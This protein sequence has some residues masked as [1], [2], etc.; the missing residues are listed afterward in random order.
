MRPLL[1]WTGPLGPAWMPYNGALHGFALDHLM[2]INLLLVCG[3]LLVSHLVLIVAIFRKGSGETRRGILVV[4]SVALVVIVFVFVWMAAT[5][6]ALWARSGFVGASPQAMQVEAVGAQFQWYFRYPGKDAT[7]GKTRP[8]L[9]DAAGGNPLGIDPQDPA[10]KD[11]LVSSQL[12]LPVGREVDLELRSQDVIHSFSI[13]AMRVK[14]DAVPAMVLHIHF[15]PTLPGDYPI[16]CTQL[17]GLG[18]ERMQARLRVV[19]G[20]EYAAWLTGRQKS[21]PA[22]GGAE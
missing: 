4:Q 12:I 2:K 19:P 14:Q 22:E 8:E 10:G 13:A 5:S 6:Q 15:T 3:A 1:E 21:L 11:D 18:H 7:F 16:S 9:V 20:A 17:C